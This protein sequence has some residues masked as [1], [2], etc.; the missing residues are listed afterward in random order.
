L[1]SPPDRAA[2]AATIFVVI[3]FCVTPFCRALAAQQLERDSLRAGSRAYELGEF[4]RA[5]PLLSY[6]LN[7]AAG[8]GD[9][10][11][12]LSLHQLTHALLETGRAPLAGVWLR[13]ALRH[14]G[15]MRVDD[16][17]FPPG[18]LSAFAEAARAVERRVAEDTLVETR[19]VW[20][21]APVPPATLGALRVT[22][23]PD[24]S[25]G[26][27]FSLAVGKLL[28][29]GELRWGE[30]RYLAPGTYTIR[31]S[32]PGLTQPLSLEREVLPGIITDL[33]F[34]DLNSGRLYVA[35]SPSA[36][37]YLDGK[38][39]GIAPEGV[40]KPSQRGYRDGKEVAFVWGVP[41][42]RGKH[43][44]VLESPGYLGL[45]TAI[46]IEANR[47]TKMAF[48]LSLTGRQF[49]GVGP[50]AEPALLYLTSS[51]AA[52]VYVD[53]LS[54]GVAP[55][56]APD[57]RERAYVGGKEAVF[58][59]GRPLAPGLHYIAVQLPG[60]APFDTLVMLSAKQRLTLHVKLAKQ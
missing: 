51:P 38:F 29:I 60:Y 8:G 31:V 55:E 53:G 19:W 30:V 44:L 49:A 21:R 6:G 58:V 59:W 50:G 13:W 15:A 56:K 40:P 16:A 5:V 52:A 7:P 18:V 23:S 26:L 37:V 10:L 35:S 47:A 22:A 41:V 43:E 42:S 34:R 27:R 33:Q 9:S 32:G 2:A 45:D 14:Q 25:A 39:L 24:S 57:P 36:L 11:W 17:N 4:E 3:A 20:P 46:V 12:V 48:T 1:P 54:V 28:S